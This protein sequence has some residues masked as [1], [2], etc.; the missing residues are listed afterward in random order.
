MINSAGWEPEASFLPLYPSLELHLSFIMQWQFQW[1]QA[2]NNSKGPEE[3]DAKFCYSLGDNRWLTVFFSIDAENTS[4]PCQFT[5]YKW[6]FLK[7]LECYL[8]IQDIW[9]QCNPIMVEESISGP[10]KENSSIS[11]FSSFCFAFFFP[12]LFSSSKKWINFPS[13]CGERK[14]KILF[15]EFCNSS[16]KCRVRSLHEANTWIR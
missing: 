11:V 9:N 7:Y 1:T 10:S 8:Y 16:E 2:I 5:D 15:A 14:G 13:P 3:N 12:S 4:D 6:Y